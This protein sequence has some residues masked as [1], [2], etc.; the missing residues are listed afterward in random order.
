MCNRIDGISQEEVTLAMRRP[1]RAARGRGPRY[2]KSHGPAGRA[3]NER[4]FCT[5]TRIRVKLPLLIRKTRKRIGT[6]APECERDQY[7]GTGK[8]SGIY[9]ALDENRSLKDFI[10]MIEVKRLG[11]KIGRKKCVAGPERSDKC[12]EKREQIENENDGHEQIERDS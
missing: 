6:Q 5:A 4:G 1:R 2:A 8:D 3:A 12:A 7:S 11:R 9:Q 10:V